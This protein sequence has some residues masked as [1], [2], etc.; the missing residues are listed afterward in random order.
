MNILMSHYKET[1][2]V[3][4][5]N[6]LTKVKAVIMHH[7]AEWELN[8][9]ALLTDLLDDLQITADD[10]VDF[11]STM[12]DQ[13]EGNEAFQSAVR[14]LQISQRRSYLQAM[15]KEGSDRFDIQNPAEEEGDL[16]QM[17]MHAFNIEDYLSLR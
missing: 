11:L 1:Y 7:S 14:S 6:A 4:Q 5:G 8:A 10:V 9:D 3:T 13:G 2:N 15:K 16:Y 17:P 12:C